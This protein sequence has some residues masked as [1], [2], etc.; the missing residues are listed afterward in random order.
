M[1]LELGANLGATELNECLRTL[2]SFIARRA[3]TGEETKEY[4]KFFGEI[5]GLLKSIEP[6]QTHEALQK[7]LLSGGGATRS[8]PTDD[9]VV[10]NG[11]K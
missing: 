5:I 7:K 10:E 6:G 9:A 4:N 2:E 1:F 3:I 11:D 8:W